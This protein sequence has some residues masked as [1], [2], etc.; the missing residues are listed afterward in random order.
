MMNQMGNR[1]MFDMNNNRRGNR[2]RKNSPKS[3]AIAAV[4]L[5]L[6]QFFSAA[7]GKLVRS[8]II[9]ILVPVL[10]IALFFFVFWILGKAALKTREKEEVKTSRPT[11]GY[12]NTCSDE[13]VYNNRQNEYNENSAEQNFYR[14][15]QRRLRQLDDFL[16]NGLIDKNE[17]L[18]LRSRYEK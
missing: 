6:L 4:V 3:V 16:K 14:D 18:V 12:C 11:D 10:A 9:T 7:D 5:V 8:S 15:K 1:P 17:Y 13:F 2:N